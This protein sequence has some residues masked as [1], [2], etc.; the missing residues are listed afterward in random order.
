[1]YTGIM[2]CSDLMADN[3]SALFVVSHFINC[4][5]CLLAVQCRMNIPHLNETSR[6]VAINEL[7]LFCSIAMLN[8][9]ERN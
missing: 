3:H 8:E 5:N 6:I 7:S 1:M 2:V 4:M 9:F